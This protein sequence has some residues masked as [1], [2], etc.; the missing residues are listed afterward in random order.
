MYTKIDLYS[1]ERCLTLICVTIKD[2]VVSA[3]IRGKKIPSDCVRDLISHISGG[4]RSVSIILR[5]H[6]RLFLCKNDK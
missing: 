3:D 6:I 5:Q 1:F 2:S 4:E